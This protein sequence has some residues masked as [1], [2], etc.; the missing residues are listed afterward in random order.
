MILVTQFKESVSHKFPSQK[1]CW[2]QK[3]LAKEQ[4][5]KQA[6]KKFRDWYIELLQ[7]SVD[8]QSEKP[9]READKSDPDLKRTNDATCEGLKQNAAIAQYLDQKELKEQQGF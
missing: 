7:E 5:Q 9:M 8:S 3:T 2:E 4:K 6:K 1:Q